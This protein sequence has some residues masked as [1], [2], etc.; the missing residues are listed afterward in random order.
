LATYSITFR[1][2]EQDLISLKNIS[3]LTNVLIVAS[4]ADMLTEE[5]QKHQAAMILFQC[6]KSDIE[7][8]DSKVYPITNRPN[9]R[10]I[11]DDSL[12]KL[13]L[14]KFLPQL[15]QRVE[16]EHYENYREKEG[17]K[18]CKAGLSLPL[19]ALDIQ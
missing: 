10:P 4:K 12:E 11:T 8:F 1:L 14:C 5:E 19:G 3:A 15:F 13:L 17:H 9:A 18:I 7:L 16:D 6:E 2:S